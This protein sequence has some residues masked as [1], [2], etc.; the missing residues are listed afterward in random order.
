MIGTTLLFVLAA[1]D[2]AVRAATLHTM[3]GPEIRDAVVIVRDGKIAEVGPASKVRIPAGAKVVEAAVVTPGLIDAR[4]TVGVSGLLNTPHDQD[5][6]D[7]SAPVQA[8]LRAIDA[9][10]PLDPLVAWVRGFGVTTVHTGH[11]PGELVPGQTAVIKTN[12]L[13]VDAA[14]VKPFASV[15]VTL[16]PAGLRS[17]EKSPGT[18]A[19]AVAMLRQE[20]IKARE[21]AAKRNASAEDKKPGRD[22]ELETMAAVLDRKVPLSI[23]ANRAQDISA[24]LRLRQE[25]GFDLILD[26]GSEA[27]MLLDDLKAAKVP[28]IVHPPM[29][30]AWGEYENASFTTAAVLAKA[31][32]PVALQGGY[33][34]YVPKAR[35]V[36]F[37]AQV[38]AAHGLGDE[39]ALRAITIDAARILGVA[40][41]IGSIEVG[42]DADLAMFDGDPFEYTTH[43][44]GT[45]IQ[46]REFAGERR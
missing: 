30:R 46:G 17:G 33:E 32:I 18:R 2:V 14:V 11:A 5:Q 7:R 39:G 20:L 15:A 36:L 23:T 45:L 35:V 6:I 21:Y 43:C 34:S 25:F 3:A 31:G 10:N 28:V 1:Q 38:A 16:G 27:P 9:F 8:D 37:E 44:T 4:C 29:Y 13:P 40:D 19:K 42:K 24:A 41:R 26:S 12:G 22:L